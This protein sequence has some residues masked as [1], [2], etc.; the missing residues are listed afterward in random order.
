MDFIIQLI[1]DKNTDCNL[2]EKITIH[3]YTEKNLQRVQHY[4]N[5]VFCI[6]DNYDQILSNTIEKDRNFVFNQRIFEICSQI[7]EQPSIFYDK[8][9]YNKRNMS[10]QKVQHNI[11]LS[12]NDKVYYSSLNYLNDLYKTHFVLVDPIKKEYYET[13]EKNYIKKYI[14]FKNNKYQFCDT[15]DP[16]IIKNNIEMCSFV[17]IVTKKIYD[18]YLMPMNK[19]KLADLQNEAKKKNINILMNGKAKIKKVLYDE[20]NIHYLNN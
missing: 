16:T 17:N 5:L 18:Y 14:S 7:E 11:Q 1:K 8:F 3:R 2:S 15:V 12:S 19:Y 10:I 20:I 6:L 13:S 4:S 9:K